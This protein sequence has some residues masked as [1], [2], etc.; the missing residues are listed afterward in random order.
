MS[1][2]KGYVGS[3]YLHLLEE[4]M[5]DFKRRSYALMNIQPDDSVL[6]VGCGPGTDTIH[7]AGLVGAAGEVVGIDYDASMVAQVNQRALE[8]GLGDLVKHEQGNATSL[9]FPDARFDS[10][11]SERLFQHLICPEQTLFEMARVTKPN[12]WVVVLDTD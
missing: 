5:M 7:L 2:L 1:I 12:G 11:R 9:P 6:D 10:S 4:Q 8:A 3:D